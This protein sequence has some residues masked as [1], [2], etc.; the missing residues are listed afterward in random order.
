M[1]TLRAMLV[2]L[3]LLL[4]VSAANAQS[5][6]V[7]AN[8][9]FDFVVGNQLM[10]A[11]SY[12]VTPLANCTGITVRNTDAPEAAMVLTHSAQK[13]DASD[14]TVLIFHRMGDEYFLSEIWTEGETR[15]VQLP[16]SKLETQLAMN[17]QDKREVIVA[18]LIAR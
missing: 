2:A 7:K 17:H 15:G 5:A 4:V 9:P 6:R 1:H 10:S 11:G 13:L 8:I 3:G 18:A 14:K 12:L 16:Q